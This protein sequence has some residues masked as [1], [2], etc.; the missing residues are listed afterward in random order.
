[1]EKIPNGGLAA[2][3]LSVVDTQLEFVY[4]LRRLC[5]TSLRESIALAMNSPTSQHVQ[6]AHLKLVEL[7]S[8]EPM[9]SLVLV[10]SLVRWIWK[11][12]VILAVQLVQRSYSQ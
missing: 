5:A 7:E 2:G 8:T 3:L 12:L 6:N 4:Y 11:M 10:D 1:M 9:M